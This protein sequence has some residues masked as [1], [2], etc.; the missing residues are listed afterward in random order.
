MPDLSD[1]AAA[2]A[3]AAALIIGALFAFHNTSAVAEPTAPTIAQVMTSTAL[4]T[5]A[6]S[7]RFTRD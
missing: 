6:Q 1:L 5:S 3:A 7:T 2:A 4:D